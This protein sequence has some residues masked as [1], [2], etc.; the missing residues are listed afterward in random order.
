VKVKHYSYFTISIF[1]LF[2]ACSGVDSR[3]NKS[4]KNTENTITLKDLTSGNYRM[5]DAGSQLESA[6]EDTIARS[7]FIIT[8][9]NPKYILKYK[10]LDYS[11]GS[12][13]GRFSTFGISKSA[14]AK[15]EVKVAL[16]D[17][18]EKVGAWTI[19]AWVKGGPLGGSPARLF[20]KAADEIMNHLRGDF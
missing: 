14:H 17:E 19:D 6:L 12:R 15:F 13:L 11:K 4:F 5:V 16:Y 10:V 20:Q 9:E 8:H 3:V 7:M 18:G 1:L 2:S